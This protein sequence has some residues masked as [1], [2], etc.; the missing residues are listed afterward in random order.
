MLKAIVAEI[1]SN[2]Q[3]SNKNL[4]RLIG[5]ELARYAYLSNR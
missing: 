1:E 4:S 2:F 3:S 5:I